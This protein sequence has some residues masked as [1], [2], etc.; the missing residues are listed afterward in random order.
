MIESSVAM[1]TLYELCKTDIW[2]RISVVQNTV[3]F[4]K[5]GLY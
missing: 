4:S 3:F 2:S 5:Q 1:E